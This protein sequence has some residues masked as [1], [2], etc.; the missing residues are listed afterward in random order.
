M[1]AEAMRHAAHDSRKM[2]A[3]S[4]VHEQNGL[5]NDMKT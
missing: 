4:N 3:Y 2:H 5:Q 1:N